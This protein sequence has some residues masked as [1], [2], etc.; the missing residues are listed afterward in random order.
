[1]EKWPTSPSQHRL[2]H[3]QP[4]NNFNAALVP[5]LTVS[6]GS[7][8]FIIIHHIIHEREPCNDLFLNSNKFQG[9]TNTHQ[10]HWNNR[11]WTPF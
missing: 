7:F 6:G 8:D 9:R 1:M 3:I 10:N 2:L 4:Q 5:L 11:N